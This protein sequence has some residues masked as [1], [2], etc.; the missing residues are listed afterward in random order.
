MPVM[1]WKPW[2]LLFWGV[3][4]QSGEPR[5]RSPFSR[6]L[7]RLPD[8]H[9]TQTPVIF[10]GSSFGGSLKG[11]STFGRLFSTAKKNLLAKVHQ[12]EEVFPVA[13]QHIHTN[14]SI[15]RA[16]CVDW[17]GSEDGLVCLFGRGRLRAG[18]PDLSRPNTLAQPSLG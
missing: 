11:G 6:Q 9:A 5:K 16:E 7:G 12:L 13:F 1:Q 17:R 4:S 10:R 15:W 14:S 18:V 8:K 3:S 2:N